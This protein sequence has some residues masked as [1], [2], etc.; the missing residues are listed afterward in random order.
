LIATAPAAGGAAARQEDRPRD[1]RVR[2]PGP[3][4]PV[5]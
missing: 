4:S 5:P 3:L 1:E 2:S